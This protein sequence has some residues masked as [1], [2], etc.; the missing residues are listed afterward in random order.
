MA[1]TVRHLAAGVEVGSRQCRAGGYLLRALIGSVGRK[2]AQDSPPL[3]AG[4]EVGSSSA[5]PADIC[6]EH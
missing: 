5:A 4:V 3:D 1:Q 6:C 2:M